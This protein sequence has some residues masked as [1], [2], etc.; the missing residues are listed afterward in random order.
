MGVLSE[1][2]Q[3]ELMEAQGIVTHT[4]EQLPD[5]VP[6]SYTNTTSCYFGP[7]Q[8]APAD[9]LGCLRAILYF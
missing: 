6:Q 2:M 1:A 4:H 3:M 9:R 5:T 8:H 7:Q